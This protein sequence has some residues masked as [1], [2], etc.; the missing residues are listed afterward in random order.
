MLATRDA[1]S[2]A[3][4]GQSLV[5]KREKRQLCFSGGNPTERKTLV[6]STKS[7]AP[8]CIEFAEGSLSG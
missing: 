5:D 7:T 1:T 8:L 6:E 2:A 4:E 3:A